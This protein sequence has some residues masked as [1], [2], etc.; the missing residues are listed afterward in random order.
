M[1]NSIKLVALLLLYYNFNVTDV[2]QSVTC[3]KLTMT[4]TIVTLI[5]VA[6]SSSSEFISWMMD[7]NLCCVMLIS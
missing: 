6:L 7:A 3:Y 1:R 4:L 5:V 2:V